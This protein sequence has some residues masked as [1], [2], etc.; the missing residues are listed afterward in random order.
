[1]FKASDDTS[2]F[3]W[4]GGPLK[5]KDQPGRTTHDN[6][7]PN[8]QHMKSLIIAPGLLQIGCQLESIISIYYN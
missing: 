1:M 5:T 7:W 6:G 2:I 8:M 4:T 3:T